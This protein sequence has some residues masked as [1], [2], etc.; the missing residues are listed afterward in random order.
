MRY[1]KRTSILVSNFRVKNSAVLHGVDVSVTTKFRELQQTA[2]RMTGDY[3]SFENINFEKII[4]NF[5]LSAQQETPHY[6]HVHSQ[7]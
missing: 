7:C 6:N 2:T 1:E 4:S 5:C 3:R